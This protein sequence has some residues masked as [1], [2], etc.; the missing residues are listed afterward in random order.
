MTRYFMTV[1][2]AVELVLQASTLGISDPEA[3]GKIFVLDMG[4]PV[5]I[6]DLARQ[7]I[8]LAG[9]VVDK[10]VRI[11]FTGLRAGEKLTEELFHDSETLMPTKME[12]ILLANPRSA[13]L[14]VLGRA[15]DEL[16]NAARSRRNQDALGLLAHLVP[17]YRD[18][19]ND[20]VRRAAP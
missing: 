12:G 20:S 8:R 2:E 17:E 9:L 1:R 16:E 19:A 14:A 11:E 13:D 10:D 6:L 4:E 15:L 7:I 18:P 3:A 5:R